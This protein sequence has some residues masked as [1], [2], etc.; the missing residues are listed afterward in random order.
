MIGF[1]PAAAS[2]ETNASV[3]SFP[4]VLLHVPSGQDPGLQTYQRTVINIIVTMSTF[5]LRLNVEK[6]QF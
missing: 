5:G 1:K 4:G 2:D 3:V 6:Q